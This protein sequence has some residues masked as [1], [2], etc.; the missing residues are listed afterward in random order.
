MD[1]GWVSAAG[2]DPVTFLDK[3]PQRIRMLH[4]KA[5]KAA[6]GNLNLVGPNAPKATE[7]GRGKPDYEP[8]FAA[9][10]KAQVEQYYIEQEP[11]FVEMPALEAVKVD[12]DYL[13]MLRG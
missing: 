2:Y 6:P 5:F 4:I 3:Y 8:I 10:A 9:A 12:Y 11:P 13:H 1:C 7:L